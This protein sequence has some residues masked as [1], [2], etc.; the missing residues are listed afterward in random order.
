[1]DRRGE[2]ADRRRGVHLHEHEHP[3]GNAV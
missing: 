1:G 2:P 3:G